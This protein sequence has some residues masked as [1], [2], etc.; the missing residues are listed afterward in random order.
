MVYFKIESIEFVNKLAPSG[1]TPSVE[2]IKNEERSLDGTMNVDVIGRK[3]RL[4]VT[5]DML[6]AQTMKQLLD[7]EQAASVLNIGYYDPKTMGMK[8]IKAYVDG[9]E[10]SPYFEGENINWKDISLSLIEI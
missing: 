4:E 2:I 9:L 8:A 6:D 1:I 10:Y 5:W 3:V 7:L